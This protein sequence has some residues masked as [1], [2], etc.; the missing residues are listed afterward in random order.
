MSGQSAST[1][2]MTATAAVLSRA[3]NRDVVALLLQAIQAEPR[4]PAR[5]HFDSRAVAMRKPHRF[6]T[7]KNAKPSG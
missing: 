1:C 2:C 4:H 6:S 5:A 7:T 3:V